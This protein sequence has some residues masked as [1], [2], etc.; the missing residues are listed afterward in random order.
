MVSLAMDPVATTARRLERRAFWAILAGELGR[1]LAALSFVLG[2]AILVARVGLG[3]EARSLLPLLGLLAIAPAL[4]WVRARRRRLSREAAAA[5]LDVRAGAGGVLVTGLEAPDPRWAPRVEAVLARA[6]ALPRPRLVRPLGLPLLGA[7]FVVAALAVEVPASEPGPSPALFEAAL[8]RLDEQ[9]A[10]LEEEVELEE[11]LAREMHERL[12]RLA[13]DLDHSGAESTYEAIDRLE[14]RLGAEARRASDAA[15]RAGE[16]LAGASATAQADGGLAL[17]KLQDALAA[18]REG[19][20]A[21]ALPPSLEAE[22]DA[23][24]AAAAAGLPLAGA[25]LLEL[26]EELR[27][28]LQAKLDGLAAAGLTAPARLASPGE[29]AS[30]DGFELRPHDH[31]GECEPGGT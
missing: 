17:E 25:K 24:E 28:L 14:E 19:G 21:G 26:S 10:T 23:L 29:F 13:E 15:R 9:L 1:A 4:A 5:W 11:E 2:A 31:E 27:A 3:A 16:A 8:Q 18:L 22:L 20:L 12:E 6:P 7:L 30:L